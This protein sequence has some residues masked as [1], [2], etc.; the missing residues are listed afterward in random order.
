MW[1]TSYRLQGIEAAE[2]TLPGTLPSAWTTT[3]L[4]G[5]N[6]SSNYFGTVSAN[7]ATITGIHTS[8]LSVGEFV[9]GTGIP[10]NSTISSI[11]AGTSSIVLNHTVT[12]SA[13]NEPLSVISAEGNNFGAAAGPAPTTG[14]W[15][16]AGDNPQGTDFGNGGQTSDTYPPRSQAH[17]SAAMSRSAAELTGV[18][19]SSSGNYYPFAGLVMRT[20]ATDA[21]AP[22]VALA[23]SGN[24]RAFFMS[25]RNSEGGAM[26][27]QSFVTTTLTA[28]LDP[29]E[30]SG[31][32]SNGSDVVS[33]VS[34]LTN[35]EVGQTVVANDIPAGTTVST[36]STSGG[37]TTVTLSNASTATGSLPLDLIIMPVY[38]KL[39]ELASGSYNDFTGYISSDGAS[40][41]TLGTI[42]VASTSFSTTP[43]FAADSFPRR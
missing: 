15:T 19:P 6:Y 24:G 34:G 12:T 4:G 8:G 38:M 39:S 7:S 20:S 30:I 3:V 29:I 10:T 32:V 33:G 43:G 17:R 21:S 40:W 31:S 42:S 26:S 16:L 37:T 9:T 36:W 41:T 28:P 5:A 27:G 22:T 14:T 18:A 35:P 23:T 25:V 2:A 11:S 1:Q 13:S